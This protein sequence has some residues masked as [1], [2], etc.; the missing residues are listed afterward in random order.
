MLSSIHPR[1][2]ASVALSVIFVSIVMITGCSA[3]FSGGTTPTPPPPAATI[4][5]V[6]ASPTAITSGAAVAFSIT[7]KLATGSPAS[8]TV[9]VADGASV[10]GSMA[11]DAAGAGSLSIATLSVGIHSI[12]AAFA[13]SATQ[14]AS[15]SSA[16]TVTVTALPTIRTVSNVNTPGSQYV[17]YPLEI[18]AYI[19]PSS[20]PGTGIPTGT[21]TFSDQSGPI[22]TTTLDQFG[23]GHITL[24]TLSP[25][26]HDISVAYNGDATYL[27]SHTGS[28]GMQIEGLS[29]PSFTN[30]LKLSLPA[31][32]TAVSCADPAIIKA[33]NSSQNTWYLYCTSDALYSGDPNPHYIKIFESTDLINW[34]YDGNAF[35]GLPSWASNGHLWAPAIKYFNGQYYLYCASPS[36][37]QDTKG[38]AAIGVGT[39]ASPK[40]PFID[41]GSPVVE[42]EPTLGD[43]CDGRDRSTIDPD[44]V[45]D[46]GGQRYI[47]FGSFDGG[48]FLRKLSADGFTSDKA[49]ETQIAATNRYEDG[50]LWQHGSYWYLFSSSANCCNGPLTG[51]SVFVGRAVS[52]M[53]PF[54]DQQ[55]VAMTDMN[56]G[57]SEVLAQTGNRWIGPGGNVLFTDEAGQDYILYHAVP[58]D[59]PVYTGTTNYTAR[60][61]LIDPVYWDPYA[62]WPFVNKDLGP[63]AVPQPVPAAQPGGS[64]ANPTSSGN[65]TPR[66]IRAA[67]SVS[68]RRVQHRHSLAPMVVSALHP[69]LHVRKRSHQSSHRQFRQLL[70]NEQLADARRRCTSR[71]LR[72]RNQD[73][74][75]PPA[76]GL[77]S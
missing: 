72:G 20:G 2:P 52:P 53:G 66:L 56:T 75:Q 32:G 1:V 28:V 25:G 40:G 9:T 37:N 19:T 63:S 8:G 60:P 57:G 44:V 55:G 65:G 27:P 38:G 70:P 16:V 41:H 22:G 43:C 14:A 36:S 61:A 35:A 4:T 10:L 62:G 21:V 11:L 26:P 33:Q 49:S 68:L 74:N 5:T 64:N 18:G 47:S 31:G 51:Y 67:L 15:T 73:D 54:V 77:G 58:S 76:H 24:T 34:S 12:T 69:C 45:Q 6:T 29:R 39:S 23:L 48:I 46:S 17:G 3:G 71:R 59:A 30:P 50:F 13:G 42:P 7:V